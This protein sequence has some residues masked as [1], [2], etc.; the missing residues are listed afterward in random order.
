MAII[1]VPVVFYIEAVSFADA[2]KS[3]V[4]WGEQLTASD[5]PDNTDTAD[6]NV[7][8]EIDEDGRSVVYVET[9]DEGSS[10]DDEDDDNDD[11]NDADLEDLE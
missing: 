10:D 3:V 8:V 9:D 7:S 1:A 5:F 11:Y 2:Q 6:F 4:E